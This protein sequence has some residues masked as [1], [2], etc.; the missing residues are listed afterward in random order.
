MIEGGDEFG[1]K[2]LGIPGRPAIPAEHQL[3][4]ILQAGH[5]HLGRPDHGL[6][7]GGG[8]LKLDLGGVGEACVNIGGCEICHA[9]SLS[10]WNVLP[11]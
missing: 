2:M 5:D 7:A 3:A 9:I 11:P 8:R 10:A 6:A 1:G 4:A